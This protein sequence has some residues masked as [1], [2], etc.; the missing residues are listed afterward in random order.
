MVIYKASDTTHFI[1]HIIS[2]R[3]PSDTLEVKRHH[4]HIR[5]YTLLG[6][7]ELIGL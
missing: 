2:Q 3:T 1:L 5:A 6:T 7:Q 4:P